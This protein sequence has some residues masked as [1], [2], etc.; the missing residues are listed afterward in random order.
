MSNASAVLS[1]NKDVG[2]SVS[3]A[4]FTAICG[5]VLGSNSTL[6][7]NASSFILSSKITF[8]IALFLGIITLILLILDKIKE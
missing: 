8:A 2:K 4:M 5:F 7:N 3:L 6:D 1:T